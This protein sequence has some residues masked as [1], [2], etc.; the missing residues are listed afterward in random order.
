L[1]PDARDKTIDGEIAHVER[2]RAAN[3]KPE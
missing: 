1:A 2:L 3:I